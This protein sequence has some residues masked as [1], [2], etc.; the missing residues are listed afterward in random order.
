MTDERMKDGT[1]DADVMNV[2]RLRAGAACEDS[3]AVSFQKLKT[4]DK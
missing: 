2:N 1:R 3:Q 4:L